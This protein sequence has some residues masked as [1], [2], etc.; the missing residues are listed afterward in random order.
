MTT[1][2][3]RFATLVASTALI[4]VACFVASPTPDA[5]S[6]PGVN[7]WNVATAPTPTGSWYAVTYADGQFVALGV[8]SDV[9]VSANGATWSEYPVPSG[10]WKSVAYANGRFVALSSMLASPEE[11]V[12]TNGTSWRALTG[13]S[14]SWSAL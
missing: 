12:S 5:T 13:P 7:T 11:I 4:A 3:T 1:T 8:S 6:A 14:G 9:A 2:T 10:S